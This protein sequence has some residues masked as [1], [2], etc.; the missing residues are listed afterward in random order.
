MEKAKP[1]KIKLETYNRK[2]IFLFWADFMSKLA[3]FKN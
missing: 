3:G 2:W 1:K